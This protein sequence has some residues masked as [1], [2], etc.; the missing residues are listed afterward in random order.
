[1]YIFLISLVWGL[2]AAMLFLNG[3]FV[4]AQTNPAIT[5]WLQNTTIKGRHYVAGNSTP[6][7]DDVLANVQKVQYSA[8]FAYVTTQG[9]PTYITGPFSDGNPSL[10]TAQNA[11]YKISLTPSVNGTN[12]VTRYTPEA[13][14]VGNVDAKLELTDKFDNI[15]VVSLKI[16]VKTDALIVFNGF[17]PNNDG[18]NDVLKVEGLEKTKRAALSVFDSNGREVFQAKNYKNDWDG[19]KNGQSLPEGTYFYTLDDGT[20]QNYTG[21][22]QLSR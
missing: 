17:S 7:Q 14:F 16:A 1:M 5:K 9:I 21:Y 3:H 11:I 10:A 20:G 13:N 8:N 18:F 12:L 4:F 15:E 19:T 22:I 6:I 2:F